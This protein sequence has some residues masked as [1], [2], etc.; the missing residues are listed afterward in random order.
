MNQAPTFTPIAP[1]GAWIE[2]IDLEHPFTN[3]V[4]EALH[5]AFDEYHLLVARAPGLSPEGQQR[6]AAVFGP[7]L[8]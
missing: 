1:F 3:E 4:V 8:D 6:L 5:A 2:Q 7:L